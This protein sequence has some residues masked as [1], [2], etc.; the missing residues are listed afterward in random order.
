[1]NLSLGF[2]KQVGIFFY[3][4]AKFLCWLLPLLFFSYLGLN[5][6]LYYLF[7]DFPIEFS[8]KTILSLTSEDLGI[9]LIIVFFLTIVGI[10]IRHRE[11]K[12]VIKFLRFKSRDEWLVALITSFFFSIFFIKSF[13]EL[14]KFEPIYILISTIFILAFLPQFVL[15]Y[16]FV[17]LSYFKKLIATSAEKK[18]SLSEIKRLF[19]PIM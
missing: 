10:Y 19:M 15:F 14:K 2:T 13:F 6:F 11:K 8:E 1:M 5:F 4:I 17:D 9:L 7:P 12:I 3:E 18:P 16:S